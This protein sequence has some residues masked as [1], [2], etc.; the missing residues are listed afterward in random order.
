MGPIGSA[1]D[2]LTAAECDALQK[3]SDFTA[4]QENHFSCFPDEKHMEIQEM[5]L[6]IP[7]SCLALNLTARYK[8]KALNL[9]D[10]QKLFPFN[11]SLMCAYDSYDA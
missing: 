7:L 8:Y 9:W 2:L 3:T 4:L 11:T 1:K 6:L 10:F 5:P